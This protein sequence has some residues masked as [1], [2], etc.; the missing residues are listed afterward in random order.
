MASYYLWFKAFH[1]VS[2]ICWMVGLLYLP[3]LYAY[4]TKAAIGSEI[5]KTFQVMENRL[6][7]IIMNPAM[8]TTYILGLTNAYIYGLVA[9]GTWFHIKM[10]AVL[11][12]TVFHGLLAR[13]RKN[14]ADG[15]N[16]HTEKFF[17]TINEI[18]TFFMIVAVI[19]V[20]VKPFD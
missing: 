7:R 8:I 2:V 1:L 5:D 12:L 19:M 10:T 3:R 17:R 14:F 13:W 20:I 18:P 4:H 15:Q 9:L 11:G 6:L 16:R